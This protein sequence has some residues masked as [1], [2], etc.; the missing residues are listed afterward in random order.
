MI[1]NTET[2]LTAVVGLLAGGFGAK[3][4]DYLRDRR[5]DNASAEL[6]AQKQPFE[7]SIILMSKLEARVDMCEA[8]LKECRASH[9]K[10]EHES[11]IMRGRLEELSKIVQSNAAAIGNQ[12]ALEPPKITGI[13]VLP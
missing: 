3:L 7:Q 6:A 2:V 9:L 11:G 4:L 10:C 12:A 13:A 5:K 8:E 1:V